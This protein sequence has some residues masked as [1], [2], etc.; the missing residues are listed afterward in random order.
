LF[1]FSTGYRF[2][3]RSKWGGFWRVAHPSAPTIFT[4]DIEAQADDTTP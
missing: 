3:M 4:L 1:V 2:Q